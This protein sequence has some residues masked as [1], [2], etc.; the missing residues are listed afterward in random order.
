MTD[1]LAL[2]NDELAGTGNNLV[3]AEDDGSD[4][5]L[6]CT[7]AYENAVELTIERHTWNFGTNVVA[8]NRVA[9]SPDDLY[10]DAF[11]KPP[12]SLRL[13]WVRIND[14]PVDYKIINN[15][16]CLSAHGQPVKAKHVVNPGVQYWPPI[17][18]AVIRLYVRAAIYRGLHEDPDRADK[19][20]GKAEAMLH[21]A[22]TTV[23]QEQPKRALFNS[24]ARMSRRM[25]R[26][27]TSSTRDF[28]GTGT[29]D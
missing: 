21:E 17:F 13:I 16:V 18:A 10:D 28:G 6:A 22:R 29:P 9:A 12:S 23:D 25:R 24:R 3:S 26:P 15:W 19:E 8:L 2:I 7:G 5:W 20:E 1:K 27:W 14:V 11:A 4:E